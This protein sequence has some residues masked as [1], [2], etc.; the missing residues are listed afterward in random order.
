MRWAG[1]V[2]R[3]GVKRNEYRILMRK[4]EGKRSLERPRR[5]RENNIKIDLK[6]IG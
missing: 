6:G 2:A 5:R 1:R 3:R 4:P